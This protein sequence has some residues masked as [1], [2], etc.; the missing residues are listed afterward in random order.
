MQRPW[1]ERIE[2]ASLNAWPAPRQILY[3]GWIL[4]F[5]SGYT[6]RANSV[7]PRYPSTLPVNEKIAYCEKMYDQAGLPVIFRLPEPFVPEGLESALKTAGYEAFDPTLV[8]GREIHTQDDLTGNVEVKRMEKDAWLCLRADLTGTSL[9]KWKKHGEI[10][11]TIVPSKALFGLFESG[12]PVACGMGVVEGKLLGYFS[13]LTAA[14]E[15]RKGYGKMMMRVLTQWGVNS[16]ADYGYLQVEDHN[17][18]A[19]VMYSHLGFDLCYTYQY[20]RK[21]EAN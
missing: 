18:P 4:R 8:L 13:V 20:F 7:N 19:K 14:A 1:L 6:K 3:D 11:N 5:A 16:G 9:S 2:E 12:K 10:L 15:Q 21:S 17:E